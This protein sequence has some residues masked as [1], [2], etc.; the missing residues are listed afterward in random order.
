MHDFQI[1][2]KNIK[3]QNIFLNECNLLLGNYG[4]HQTGNDRI[5][6]RELDDNLAY[7]P[8]E[9]FTNGIKTFASDIWSL[10]VIFYEIINGCK[11]FPINSP[12]IFIRRLLKEEI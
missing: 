2:H 10:G 9:V 7:L 6:N 5:L 3:P 12:S 8:P 11:P 4:F 1:I